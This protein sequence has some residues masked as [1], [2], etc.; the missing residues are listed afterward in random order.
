LAV[1]YPLIDL[2]RRNLMKE[3]GKKDK[4]NREKKKRPEH[5]LKE[6]RKLKEEKKQKPSNLPG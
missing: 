5:T 4:G 6:K 1:K 3:K 2:E